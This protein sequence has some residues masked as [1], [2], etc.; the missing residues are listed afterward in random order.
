MF[1]VQGLSIQGKN[2][3]HLFKTVV[4]QCVLILP[5]IVAGSGLTCGQ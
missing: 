2:L 4:G 1:R 5:S 3:Y